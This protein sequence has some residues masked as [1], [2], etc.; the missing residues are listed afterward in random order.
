MSKNNIQPPFKSQNQFLA[1][2]KY[3]SIGDINNLHT[4]IKWNNIYL[5]THE[6][7]FDL[8]I[9]RLDMAKTQRMIIH[10]QL[11]MTPFRYKY[12]LFGYKL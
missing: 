3:Q 1:K 4:D 6:I 7:H 11:C 12:I 10:R 2:S 9:P 8:K 5:K